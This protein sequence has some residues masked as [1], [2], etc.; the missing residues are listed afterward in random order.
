M[1]T[2]AFTTFPIPV[3]AAAVDVPALDTR[4]DVLRTPHTLQDA[5][6]RPNV[7]RAGASRDVTELA[8]APGDDERGNADP[9]MSR[10]MSAGV[11]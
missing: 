1:T 2:T 11:P 5:G 8:R 3:R 4:R 9:L 7:A 10:L 6:T